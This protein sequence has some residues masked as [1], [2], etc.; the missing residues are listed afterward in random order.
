[1]PTLN[2]YRTGFIARPFEE[3]FDYI[4]NAVEA[5][6]RKNRIRAATYRNV[7][8][9][10]LVVSE[11]LV[12]INSAHFG[13]A[14]ITS[15]NSNVLFEIGAMIAVGKPLVIMRGKNDDAS[16]PFDIAGYDCYRY[17]IADDR[18]LISDATSQRP[19]EE[20]V[21]SF[22]SERL[23]MDKAFRGAKEYV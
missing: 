15:L 20:F 1:V 17:A 4:S 13:I 9:S 12:Q 3:K 21:G 22:I 7:A 10:T 23:L 2:P 18:I 14:D 19:L 5:V 11:M 6:F 8:G 16:L